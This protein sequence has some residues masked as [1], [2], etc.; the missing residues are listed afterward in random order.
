M[1]EANSMTTGQRAAGEND[2]EKLGAAEGKDSSGS[3]RS[4]PAALT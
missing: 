1:L 4:M 3:R 2:M